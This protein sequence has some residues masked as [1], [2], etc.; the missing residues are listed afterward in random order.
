MRYYIAPTVWVVLVFLI[1]A[2]LSMQLFFPHSEVG[3]FSY[4]YDSHSGVR[5][6]ADQVH[7]VRDGGR[8]YRPQSFPLRPAIGTLRLAVVG[9]S[10]PRGNDLDSSYPKLLEKALVSYDIKAHSINAGVAGQGVR[11][12]QFIV[13]Q[14]LDFN[15]DWIVFH[16]NNSNEF[17][18]EREW[19]RAQEFAGW[20][21]ENWLMK[22]FIIRRLFEAKLEQVYWKWLP[23]EV[24]QGNR[25][26]DF[27]AEVQ[28]SINVATLARWN[29]LVQ[30]V[31][32]EIVQEV[33]QR[34]R[35]MVLIVQAKC[36]CKQPG[37]QLRRNDILESIAQALATRQPQRI[38]IV[39][40]YDLFKTQGHQGMFKDS[41]HLTDAGH[42]VLGQALADTLVK[43]MVQH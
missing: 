27:D 36:E 24:R 19:L 29:H 25:H 20:S 37:G 39:S 18:D 42:R 41:A 14:M 16:L 34:Q 8:R 6:E 4:G 13:Q 43:G 31:S 32:G 40:M 17:E 28:A 7:L 11:R 38:L 15:S 33:M 26:S 2:E 3:R 21:P 5:I 35:S 12:L 23:I 1:V 9:D 30:L 10:V 22:S